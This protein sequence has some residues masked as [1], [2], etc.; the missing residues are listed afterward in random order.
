MKNLQLFDLER[1]DNIIAPEHFLQTTLYSPAIEVFTD[2]KHH[3]VLTIEANTLAV[4]ALNLMIKAHV[5]MKV[6]VT[7]NHDFLGIITTSELSEQRIVAEVAKGNP[8]NEILV[9]DLMLPRASL[10]AFDYQEISHSKVTD[11]VNTLENYGLRHCLVV[12]RDQHHIRG[13]ISSSDIARKLH[14]PVDIMSKSSFS[15]VYQALYA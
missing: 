13:L 14:L 5:Q 2:F 4:D 8:R 10:H 11:V 15:H 12:D 9:R 6:V 7:D 1:V 3:E